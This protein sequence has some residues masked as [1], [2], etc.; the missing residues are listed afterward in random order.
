MF[1][2]IDLKSNLLGSRQGWKLLIIDAEL[3]LILVI[4]SVL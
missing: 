4:G 1:L 2:K 3:L